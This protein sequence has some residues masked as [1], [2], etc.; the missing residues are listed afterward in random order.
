MVI[1]N[2]KWWMVDG[3]WWMVDGGWGINPKSK[4]NQIPRKSQL[5]IL[6][7]KNQHHWDLSFGISLEVLVLI[8]IIG[9]SN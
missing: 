5:P 6:P 7:K 9:I 8:G 3:G 4:Y 1:V 2:S